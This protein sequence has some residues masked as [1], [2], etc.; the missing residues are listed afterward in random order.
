MAEFVSPA[1]RAAGEGLAF[2]EENAGVAVSAFEL[3][4]LRGMFAGFEV[5]A[6]L[7]QLVHGKLR[8]AREHARA[9]LR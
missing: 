8:A 3:G 4:V 5:H 1:F 6:G 2:V 7:L 9:K